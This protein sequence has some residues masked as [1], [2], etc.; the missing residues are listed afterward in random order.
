MLERN[1]A[2]IW[3]KIANFSEIFKQKIEPCENDAF[4]EKSRKM[5]IKMLQKFSKILTN[6]QKKIKESAKISA[7]FNEK[8]AIRERCKGVHSVN[9][10]ESFPTSIY[11]QKL[12]SMQPRT[13]PKKF[14]SSSSRECEFKTLKLQSSFLQPR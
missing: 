1:L 9:L 3:Q 4:W 5:L 10:G 6:L 14:E 7:F 2:E 12:A 8:V 11:L 13:S